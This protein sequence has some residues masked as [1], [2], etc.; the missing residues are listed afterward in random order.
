MIG[1]LLIMRRAARAE[2]RWECSD[3]IRDILDSL[4]AF[5]FDEKDGEQRVMR[6]DEKFFVHMEKAGMLNNMTFENRR[7][8]LKWRIQQ[9]IRAN[10]MFDAWLFT[11]NAKK[12]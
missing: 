1:Y 4:G 12:M 3:V 11:M 10:K 2:K 5:V 8:Y 7:E 9:D 6:R